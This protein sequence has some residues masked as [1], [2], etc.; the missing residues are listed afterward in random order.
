MKVLEKKATKWTTAIAIASS[1]LFLGSFQEARAAELARSRN[2]PI[3]KNLV[4]PTFRAPCSP[5]AVP[6][7]LTKKEVKRLTANA[8]LRED[9]LKLARYYTA[10]AD[11]LNAQA[12]GYQEAAAHAANVKN[13]AAPSTAGRYEFFAEGFRDEAQSNRVL[14]AAHEEMAK[15]AAL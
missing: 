3:V 4:A 15:H 7:G 11:R 12:A 6:E 9:H 8:E 2:C 1:C 10:E 5:V 13:L 14:A